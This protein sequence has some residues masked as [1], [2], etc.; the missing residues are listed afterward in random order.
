MSDVI[1]IA[2]QS[3]MEDQLTRATRLAVTRDRA[4]IRWDKVYDK[5]GRRIWHWRFKRF[6]YKAYRRTKHMAVMDK[7][8]SLTIVQTDI[9]AQTK[10]RS[11]VNHI[12]SFKG[13]R[14]GF[15]RIMG[16]VIT[17]FNPITYD[18]VRYGHAVQEHGK[19]WPGIQRN[20]KRLVKLFLAKARANG[21]V[22][23]KW[24]KRDA[25]SIHDL[26]MYTQYPAVHDL[27]KLGFTGFTK[28]DTRIL[29]PCLRRP[30]KPALKLISGHDSTKLTKLLLAKKHVL[31]ERLVLLRLLKGILPIDHI[32]QVL[33][34]DKVWN[35]SVNIGDEGGDTA[36]WSNARSFLKVYRDKSGVLVR[37]IT[38]CE[39]WL[40]RDTLRDY[41]RVRQ[42]PNFAMPETNDMA[43]LH[44]IWTRQ[45]RMLGVVDR[46]I[47]LPNRI[48][49]SGLDGLRVGE[50]TLV[51][52]KTTKELQGW[53]E[54][55]NN[56]IGSYV[57]R[58]EGGHSDIFALVDA[59]GVKYGIEFQPPTH[60]NVD[61]EEPI[62]SFTVPNQFKGKHN[63]DAPPELVQ[64]TLDVIA[65]FLL[66]KHALKSL[67]TAG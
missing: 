61:C 19:D 22:V 9:N 11:Q 16:K 49:E 65:A 15:F 5:D 28:D 42:E 39:N 7:P 18:P 37:W 44:T 14:L 25:K 1:D 24:V 51:T 4:Y 32:H 64:K 20:D 30:L 12:I 2:I 3:D 13:G 58:I 59:E 45:V 21:V 8:H 43:E 67:D 40:W 66:A 10:Q 23:P 17:R 53:G 31:T 62:V 27:A 57:Q 46:P 60:I 56:C 48:A 63:I 54:T 36:G 55:L 29:A 38:T 52:P 33:E 26:A 6:H 41:A 50:F 35:A 34:S 47:K